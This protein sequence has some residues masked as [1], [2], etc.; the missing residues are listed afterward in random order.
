MIAWK[1]HLLNPEHNNNSTSLTVKLQSVFG[2]PQRVLGP[3]HVDPEVLPPEVVD[4]EQH[5]GAVAVRDLLRDLSARVDE[6]LTVELPV[7]NRVG[8]GRDPALE[9]D[10]LGG[11]GADQLALHVDDGFDCRET[12]ATL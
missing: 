7:V 10:G 2:L 3:T 9:G 12:I 5:A 6:E 4:G 11:R 1:G 8:E